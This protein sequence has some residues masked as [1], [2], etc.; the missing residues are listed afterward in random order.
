[1][2]RQRMEV[3]IADGEIAWLE[4]L[5]PRQMI[6]IGDRLWSEQRKRLIDDLKDAEVDSAE[7][8]VALRDLDSRRGL[9]S[10]IVHHAI[11][12]HGSL[13]IIAE[14]AKGGG[15]E[16]AEGLPDNFAGTAEDANK[17]A[18]SPI[19]AELEESP[20]SDQSKKKQKK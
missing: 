3:M 4:R 17:I 11:G 12:L 18:L 1:M 13:E 2:K 10:E 14:A 8:I 16:N 15:A 9:M 19:G 6:S 5:T 7:K 20:V